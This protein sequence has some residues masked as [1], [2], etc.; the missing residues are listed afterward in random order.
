MC[1][2]LSCGDSKSV[3]ILER[4]EGKGREEGREGERE[5]RG[6]LL[7]LTDRGNGVER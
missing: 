4:G 7:Q 1:H 5:E 6:L 2:L 3:W